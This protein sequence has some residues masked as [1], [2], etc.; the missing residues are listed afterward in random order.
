MVAWH[1]DDFLREVTKR[2]TGINED[3]SSF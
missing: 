2:T 3:R 1:V